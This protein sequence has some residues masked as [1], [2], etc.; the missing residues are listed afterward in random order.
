MSLIEYYFP[1]QQ[2]VYW[3]TDIEKNRWVAFLFAISGFHCRLTIFPHNLVLFIPG[4]PYT[5]TLRQMSGPFVAIGWIRTAR[6]NL[7]VAS[8]SV[9]ESLPLNS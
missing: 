2:D 1:S 8:S 7:G 5:P 6:A 3:G 4:V 9:V